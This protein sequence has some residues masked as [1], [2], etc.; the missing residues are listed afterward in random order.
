MKNFLSDMVFFRIVNMSLTS[1]YIIAI[2]LLFRLFLK[3]A[4]KVFSYGLWFAVLFRLLCPF[5]LP[6]PVS[7]L[8]LVA[9]DGGRAGMEYVPLDILR[10]D[11]P[12][13]SAGTILP[14]DALRQT[15]SAPVDTNRQALPAPLADGSATAPGNH[16][17]FWCSIWLLGVTAFAAYVVVCAVRLRRLTRGAVETEAGIFE[18]STVPVPFAVGFFSGKPFGCGFLQKRIYLPAGLPEGE[19]RHIIAHE[20]VHLRRQ[21]PLFKALFFVALAL[22]WF[23]PLVW[24]AFYFMIRDM[25]MSCDEA[26]LRAQ[27]ISGASYGETLL[28]MARERAGLCGV[29]SFG[30]LAFGESHVA[31][32]IRNILKYKKMSHRAQL[33]LTVAFAV[34]LSAC[35]SNPL[36]QPSIGTRLRYYVEKLFGSGQD[37]TQAGQLWEYRTPYIG[38]ASAVGNLLSALTVPEELELTSAGMELSASEHPYTLRICYETSLSCSQ[39]QERLREQESRGNE[40]VLLQNMAILFALI[41]NVDMIETKI[42]TPDKADG[43]TDLFASNPLYGMTRRSLENNLGGSV[44]APASED[45]LADYI[46][47]VRHEVSGGAFPAA[48]GGFYACGEEWSEASGRV[49]SSEGGL[50]VDLDTVFGQEQPGEYLCNISCGD[51]MLYDEHG[52]RIEPD[53]LAAGDFVTIVFD[54]LIAET[55]PCV[56]DF[57]LVIHKR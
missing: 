31:M 27:D 3:K 28:S 19:R 13:I 20:Q 12:G 56:I 39:L 40:D 14:D 37:M 1:S 16:D 54:G 51:A 7:V 49:V 48:S 9:P 42:A 18:G 4:P 29:S 10:K 41:D 52:E 11:N 50:L 2:V 45:E 57:A 21:D 8:N 33:V 46:E 22:H 26:V 53:S 17:F 6:S 35:V 24:V 23:N 43:E 55:Y 36:S 44:P 30:P 25:E 38:D 32:R 34:F 15:L 47:A 5:S